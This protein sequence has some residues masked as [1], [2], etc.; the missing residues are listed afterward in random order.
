MSGIGTNG[1]QWSGN[2][3]GGRRIKTSGATSGA[4]QLK[5]TVRML[6]NGGLHTDDATVDQTVMR[7]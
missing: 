2:T 3:T 1:P 7:A 5:Y 4:G 6:M